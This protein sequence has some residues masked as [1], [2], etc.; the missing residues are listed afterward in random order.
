MERIIKNISA[1]KA[2]VPELLA[3]AGNRKKWCFYGDLG[4]GKTTLIK[5][6]AA[7]LGIQEEVTSPTYSLINEY[8]YIEET[9]KQSFLAFHMDLYRLKTIEEALDIG[10]E[11]YLERSEYCFMEWPELIEPLL[12]EDVV[13]ITIEIV[14]DSERKIVFL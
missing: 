9:T 14:K 3:A 11:D 12:P 1:L 10:I 2:L 4:S 6:I 7:Q 5:A 8:E 13:K